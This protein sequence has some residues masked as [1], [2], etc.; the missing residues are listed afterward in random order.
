MTGGRGFET[1]FLSPKPSFC[2]LL[3]SVRQQA[4]QAQHGV[5]WLGEAMQCQLVSK[6]GAGQAGRAWQGRADLQEAPGAAACLF[7]LWLGNT[8]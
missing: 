4:R 5:R 7:A 8:V 3:D 1:A 2:T 6:S